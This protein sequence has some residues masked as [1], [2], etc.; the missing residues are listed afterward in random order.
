MKACIVL[1]LGIAVLN[2]SGCGNASNTV[3]KTGDYKTTINEHLLKY[4][5]R[6]GDSIKR[7]GMQIVAETYENGQARKVFIFAD[8]S[9]SELIYEVQYYESGQRKMEGPYLEGNRH[10]KWMAWYENDTVWS[11]GYYKQGKRHGLSAVYHPNGI[12]FY[13]KNYI[14]NVAEGKWSFY[15]EQG[16]LVSEAFYHKGNLIKENNY[17]QEGINPE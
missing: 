16:E 14:N 6:S 1:L 17:K 4:E 2:L 7:A 3:A 15:S 13:D 10:G 9:Y 5:N 11:V 12:K 8:S